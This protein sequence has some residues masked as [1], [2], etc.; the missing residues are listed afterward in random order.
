MAVIGTGLIGTSVAIAARRRGVSVFLSDGNRSAVRTAV[1][2]GAGVAQRPA[3]PVDLAVLA[4]P[5]NQVGTLLVELQGSGLARCYTDVASVKAEPE[6]MALTCAPNPSCY[7]G[8]HPLAG[9]ERSGPL[10]ARAD[11][12]RGR[13][14]A[15]TPSRLTSSEA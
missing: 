15:L 11:L 14:W 10:A 3:E 13:P 4:V 9:R 5:P 2:L 8:G 6:R 12:F 7:I 1:A